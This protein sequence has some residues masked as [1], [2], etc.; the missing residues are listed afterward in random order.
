MT[1]VLQELYDLVELIKIEREADFEQYKGLVQDLP[2]AERKKQGFTWFPLNI[3]RT[4]YTYGD[5]AF[6]VA[7]RTT[8]F[9]Q[10]AQFRSGKIVNLFTQKPKAYLPERTGIVHY[11]D[12]NKM[13]I[14]LNSKDLPDWIHE[15]DIGVDMLFDARTYE[16]MEKAMKKVIE[17]KG[18]RLAELR[19]I[20]LGLQPPRFNE[21][22][23]TL[24]IPELNPAQN[25]A[26]REIL[27]AQD[28]A[29]VHGPPGTGKTTTLI[30]AIKQLCKTEK[31][32]LVTAP[33]NTAADVLTERLAELGLDVVRIGN[34]SRVDENIIRHTI[35]ARLS[36]HPE[37]RHIKKV[38][39][40]AAEYRRQAR[41]FR[42]KFGQKE[43]NE[44][45]QLMKEAGELSDWAKQ[46]EEQLVEAILSNAQVVTC[47]LVGATHPYLEHYTFRTAVI[48]EAAQALEPAVWIPLT[49]VSK[50]VLAGDPFQLPPTI[51]S[52]EAQQAGLNVTL[53]EKSINRLAQVSFL[54]IQY[55]MNEA[56]MEFSNR[57]FYNG[58]LKAAEQVRQQRLPIADSQPVVFIDTV[59]CGFEE[60]VKEEFKSRYNPDEF[61]ILCE[62]LYQLIEAHQLQ[63]MELP[64][65]AIISPYREQVVMMEQ[66]MKE[67]SRLVNVPITIDTIDGFQGQ[68]RDVVYISLVRSNGKGE[69]GF[70]NDYRRMNVA[71]TR[72]KL[73]L[74]IIG[75]SGTI[76]NDPFYGAFLD[77]CEKEGTYQ[78]AWAYMLS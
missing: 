25:Q 9:Q 40:Q 48:D 57:Q 62:H 54:N 49:K 71:M 20:I 46:L 13:K 10:P 72:A 47:T 6:V 18:N 59:G 31:T 69:I 55:R 33:S 42:R 77:Y 74:I 68:E 35:E 29:V 66:A 37:S 76:G 17:A 27:A 24:H 38:Q 11:V 67:D 50:V 12:K 56:I 30:H 2:L 58:L 70:L 7:E 5:R 14:I 23:T 19:S 61:Q 32:V 26:V 52:K 45:R 73:Q 41:R 44:R 36:A 63:E 51:K 53:I 39:L 16:E 75:D 1:R 4:G 60:Q 15:G 22:D 65:I 8:D 78:T 3:V 34:I 21:L 43:W 28:I 64:S